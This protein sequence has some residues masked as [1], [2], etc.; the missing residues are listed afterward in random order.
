[1]GFLDVEHSVHKC[2][3]MLASL[4]LANKA[5]L[6]TSLTRRRRGLTFDER[7]E[8]MRWIISVCVVSMLLLVTGCMTSSGVFETGKDTYSIM[9]TG[10]TIYASMGELQKSAYQKA[11]AFCRAQ[12]KEMQPV[13][14]NARPGQPYILPTFQ[15]TFRAVAPTDPEYGRPTLESVPDVKIRV[16]Q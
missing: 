12:G 9:E 4:F 5:L 1:M 8:M 3:E 6:R 11:I 16:T 2:D 13:S 10:A 15:L 14:T 7:R